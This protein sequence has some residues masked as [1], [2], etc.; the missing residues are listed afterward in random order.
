MSRLVSIESDAHARALEER[1]R[2]LRDHPELRSF[3]KKIDR[4]LDKAHSRHNRMVMIQG[5]M[6]DA[7]LELDRMLQSV[8]GARRTK[9]SATN[10]VGADGAGPGS[11]E[12]I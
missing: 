9:D 1:D 2:F 6:M 8:R 3:Q 4:N 5:L 11:H 10:S 12:P 7:F